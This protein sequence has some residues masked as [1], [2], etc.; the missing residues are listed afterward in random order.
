MS[1]LAS[2]LP[3]FRLP[4]FA[5]LLGACLTVLVLAPGPAEAKFGKW[6]NFGS[7]M[8]VPDGR[9][10]IQFTRNVGLEER[11]ATGNRPGG[12][13]GFLSGGRW[14][15]ATRLV[16]GSGLSEPS[17]L[18][19]NDPAGRR[20][21]IEVTDI[22][23]MTMHL[24]A[25]VTGTGPQP[26][27]AIGIGF[28]LKNGERLL[29]FGERSDHVN[30][31]GNEVENYVGEGPY[32]E[33]DYP[34]IR[35]TVPPWGL[36]E[37]SDATYFPMPWFISTR[38]YGVLAG[39]AETSRFRL[40]TERKGEWSFEAESRRL[41]LL[42]FAG[43]RPAG[44]LRRMTARIGRQPKP[45]APW[46]FGPWFQ[47]GHQNT[48]P[49]ELDF[50][51][52][53]REA[54]APISAVETHMRYM[55]CGSDLGQESSEKARVAGLRAGGLAT[56]TYS[57]EGICASYEGPF[58][59]AVA[60][61]AF[62]RHQ[63]GTP[64]TFNTFV[65]S[66]VTQL[67]MLDF[68][69]PAAQPI[70][71]G[72]LDR[73]YNA[74]YDGWME[75]YGE[76]APP[77]SV[78]FTGIHGKRLHNLH[79]VYYHR[80]GLRYANSK[81]RP[82]V[83]FVRSGFTGSARYSQ[84]VWGG[85]PTTGW[86]FDGLTSSVT[87]AL[88]MGLSGVSNWGS[89]IGGFFSFSP[90]KLD[91]ELLARWI[92]FGAFSGVMRSKAEGI[93]ASMASRPQI[94]EEETLPVWR[95]YAK[96]R[97][98]MYPYL[99]AANAT[100]RKS[101]MPVMRHLALTNPRD[102]KATGIEDQFMFGP[103]L[104]VSPV[105]APGSSARGVYVPRGKWVDFWRALT[106]R[107]ADGGFRL[108]KAKLFSGGRK[109]SAR[110]P[111]DEIPVMVKAGALLPLLPADTDTLAPYAKRKYTGLDDNRGKLHLIA[112]PRGRSSAGFFEKGR[113]TSQEGKRRWSLN[114]RGAGRQ[115]L[116]LEA[117][118]RTLKRPFVP[119]SV[120]AG[121]KRLSKG[122]A[123]TY[124]RRTCVLRVRTTLKPRVTLTVTARKR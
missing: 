71:A 74:G 13:V 36:R 103:D 101:G 28:G 104:L 64:Y 60:R 42:F 80:G 78:S 98:Q 10:G 15:H 61:G 32:Q 113:I 49:D 43:P 20:I 33:T 35:N 110:T 3:R 82:I 76:Y 26:V 85:D 109:V 87:E 19:T 46:I 116:D 54:D 45:K 50:V 24:R 123:W 84:I 2:G 67:G 14:Y 58:N 114:L 30:Q 6:L 29:G 48:A 77:D 89:D 52:I 94:W 7:S 69:N 70:Y 23:R 75:D 63:D 22:G 72:I 92:Q 65:G 62:I 95:R 9:I 31:R 91:P 100:Y 38:G 73:A 107:Q 51:R 96:L 4:F 86:G 18:R 79:P 44:V 105:L 68:T 27:E 111:L 117:S 90:Q 106:Y 97:T 34:I 120:R 16:D 17:I 122:R 88:T 124:N 57:R 59:E 112:L 47:T 83:S 8:S 1:L 119:R 55:P 102:R 118:M 25:E 53:L 121:G 81:K 66:G 40:G 11:A 37:R 5:G 115:R 39:N 93:G 41:S 99:L 12:R 56:I 108:G 21:K